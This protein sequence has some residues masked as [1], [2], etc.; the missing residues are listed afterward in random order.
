[1]KPGHVVTIRVSPEDCQSILDV[2]ESSGILTHAQTFP[3]MVS[4]VLSSFLQSARQGG[5]IPSVDPFLFDERMQQYRGNGRGSA[6]ERKK[7]HIASSVTLTPTYT[8]Q[9]DSTDP[10]KVLR[11]KEI[12]IRLGELFEK[13]KLSKVNSGVIWQREDQKE[14]L[15]LHKELLE[16]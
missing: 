12:A 1:M 6:R 10:S 2:M 11:Q 4:L 7:G 15:A 9:E 8:R 5:Q 14:I 3:Q 13:E 16:L